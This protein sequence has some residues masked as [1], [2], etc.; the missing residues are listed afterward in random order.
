MLS[1]NSFLKRTHLPFGQWGQPHKHTLQEVLGHP[2]HCFSFAQDPSASHLTSRAAHSCLALCSDVPFRHP[3][4][5]LRHS[6]S[7]ATKTY[8]LDEGPARLRSQPLIS[9][10]KSRKARKTTHVL[11]TVSLLQ[12]SQANLIINLPLKVIHI[13]I[14]K[15]HLRAAEF[16]LSQ[17]SLH[18]ALIGL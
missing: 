10:Q 12:S 11:I 13:F 1:S 7:N 14:N 9:Q 4:A 5:L 2:T 18:L 17:H 15:C 6:C 8:G 16:P 3:R